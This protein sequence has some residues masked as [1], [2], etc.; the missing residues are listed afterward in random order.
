MRSSSA[1]A[2]PPEARPRAPAVA[3]CVLVLL[4]AH[5]SRIQAQ[6][7]PAAE[8]PAAATGALEDAPESEAETDAPS[9]FERTLVADVTTAELGELL[10]WAR[11]RELSTRGSR[12]DVENRILQ[13]YGVSRPPDE[14]AQEGDEG[15]PGEA[16]RDPSIARIERARTSEFFEA[17][18]TG[19]EYLRL[20]G[21][22]VLTMEDGDSVHRIEAEEITL[23]L[24][25]DTLAARGGVLYQLSREDG[26]GESFRGETVVFQVDTWDGVFIDGITER[27]GDLEEGDVDFSVAG[28]RISRSPNEIIVIDDGSVTSSPADPPNYRIRADRIWLLAPGEW[29]FRRATLFV[30][31]IPAFYLP[32]FFLPGDRLFFNPAVGTRERAGAFVQTTTYLFG[33]SEER[34]PPISIMQ[35]GEAPEDRDREIRGLFL[36]IPDTPLEEDPED[37][38]LKVML[39]LYSNLGVYTGGEASLPD[40]G[41]FSTFDARLGFGASRNIYFENGQYSSYFVDDDGR[42]Q[43][44]W[45][46]GYLLGTRLPLRYEMTFDGAVREGPVT[47]DG[48][49]ELY[50]DPE[51]RRDFADR[52]EGMDWS[53]ILNSAAE[54]EESIP[55][56]VS[57]L[58]WRLRGTWRPDVAALR[59]WVR[60]VSVTPILAQM[61]F[62]TRAATNLPDAV[63]RPE[64]DASPEAQFYYPQAVVLPQVGARIDGTLLSLPQRPATRAGD[65]QGTA[66]TGSGSAG[67]PD[68]DLV[69][70]W[71]RDDPP[72]EAPDSPF[73]LPQRA[74]DERGL[75]DPQ[76]GTFTVQYSLTP[77]LRYDRFTDNEDW[78]E[79]SDAE[80]TWRYSTLQVRSG[81]AVTSTA[82]T[83]DSIAELAST[84]AFDARYQ[85]LEPGSGLEASERDSLR[86]ESFRF[87]QFTASQDTSLTIRPLRGVA[88]LE[89]S[90]LGYS[91]DTAV[92]EWTFD[93][94]SGAGNPR[95]RSRFVEWDQADVDTHQTRF[96][97]RW[98]RWGGEQRF[99]ARA[100]LPPRDSAYRGSLRA[101]TGPLT[102]SLSAGI[103]D[104]DD[105]GW[106]PD[107]LIQ[108]HTLSLLGGNLGATQR[109]DYDLDQAVLIQSAS[110]LSVWILTARLNGRRSGGFRFDPVGGWEDT[111][112]TRFR[113]VSASLSADGEQTI[114]FW[115]RRVEIT[116]DGELAINA[117]LQRFTG[118]SMDL[119]YG[120]ELAIHRFLDLE[121]TARSRNDSIYQYVPSLAREVDRPPRNL[122]TD[123]VDSLRLFDREARENSFFKIDSL[124]ISAIHDLQDWEMRFTYRGRPELDTSGSVSVYRWESE[125]AILV[126]W[127]SIS[128]LRRNLQVT[129][130]T[131]EFVQ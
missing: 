42:A 71:Q 99:E 22:V 106:T 31:R 105:E 40:F 34:E 23:N 111:G 116:L 32:V 12:V 112:G 4:T 95:Y 64:S 118:S 39:D 97:L 130:G 53:F 24:A 26:G 93:E 110:S 81:G 63:D 94:L 100:D 113:W 10:D 19:E 9:L 125:V 36:R 74:P 55:A 20:V 54:D 28:V 77:S 13:S 29:G 56:T 82:R 88:S 114:T 1:D 46:R 45:N 27:T 128:E 41:P 121:I 85:D 38:S 70:P 78:S 75:V 57:S 21:G 76:D 80:F 14:T 119:R 30:G 52:A 16:G 66:R 86:L 6:Q 59:P 102:S 83:R 60:S 127:R 47:L 50:S 5:L 11:S 58:N 91:L 15:Q 84:V 108:N 17:D 129:D 90:S 69:P 35:L 49:F 33:Q 120:V 25:S 3:L 2:A 101:V 73:R 98:D 126:R 117:D 89:A 62:R 107:P 131:V 124:D 79:P 37:W 51:F 96:D 104:R 122:A 48:E 123:L 109:L 115:R 68:R 8:E 61:T 43:T 18:L 87:R 72:G 67:A 65:P 92:Y 103:V 7:E 44:H